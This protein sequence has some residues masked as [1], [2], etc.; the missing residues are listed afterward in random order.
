MPPPKQVDS[1][2]P[3]DLVAELLALQPYVEHILCDGSR[4]PHERAA[5]KDR[6]QTV[7][8]KAIQHLP[9]YQPHKEGL[10][11]WVTRIARNEKIDVHRS[12]RR[13]ADAFGHDHI[14]AD[15]APSSGPSPER[16]AQVRE[17][18][19]R[20]WPV[21]EEMPADLQ[22]VLILSAFCEDSHAEIAK[23]LKI[24]EDAAKMRLSRARQMLRK[25]VGSIRDHVGVWLLFFRCK[26][27]ALR[28]PTLRFVWQVSHLLPPVF[29]GLVALPHF[30]PTILVSTENLFV[31]LPGDASSQLAPDIEMT[32]RFVVERSAY[33]TTPP[34]PAGVSD[35]PRPR[36]RPRPDFNVDLPLGARFMNARQ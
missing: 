10:R 2:A 27:A 20:A 29:I 15:F 17:L 36:T 5:A 16:E 34:S 9:S 22:D 35:K 13:R 4:E 23:Q 24:T 32:K 19:E 21:I 30:E 14:A 28:L 12:D 33:A 31:A 7:L 11:P 3:R 1:A 26:L 6:V 8:R 25:R 18:L